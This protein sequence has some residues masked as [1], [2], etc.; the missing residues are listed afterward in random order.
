MNIRFKLRNDIK[1]AFDQMETLG[2]GYERAT[3]QTCGDQIWFWNC[4]NVPEV[5]PEYLSE[6]DADPADWPA[7][8]KGGLNGPL[9]NIPFT[10]A[11]QRAA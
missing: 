5:L 6:L 10:F 7:P 2:I 9:L 11:V 4:T 3:P 8:P 1:N